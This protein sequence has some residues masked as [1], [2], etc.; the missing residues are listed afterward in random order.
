MS[1]IFNTYCLIGH[2]QMSNGFLISTSNR[3]RATPF[4]LKNEL[5]GVKNSTV[6]NN[7]LLPTINHSKMIIII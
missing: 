2:K 6:Y 7:T 3:I 4:S 1:K 5:A